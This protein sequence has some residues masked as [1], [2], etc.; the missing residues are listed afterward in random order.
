MWLIG[1]KKD[2]VP[3]LKKVSPVL[4]KHFDS[5]GRNLSRMKKVMQQIERIAREENVWEA[6]WTAPK[7]IDM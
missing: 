4:V 3:P 6:K 2:K 7:V 1:V 5:G